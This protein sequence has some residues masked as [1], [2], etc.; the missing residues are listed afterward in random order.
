MYKLNNHSHGKQIRKQRRNSGETQNGCAMSGGD[1]KR[2]RKRRRRGEG[3]G[4]AKKGHMLPR[5][6]LE[7]PYR[8]QVGS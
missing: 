8:G 1:K 6:E 4:R 5:R 3:K 2:K 7:A